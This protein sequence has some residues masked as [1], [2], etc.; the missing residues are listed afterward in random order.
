[1]P[2]GRRHCAKPR[3]FIV[4][5]IIGSEFKRLNETE[6]PFPQADGSSYS[7]TDPTSHAGLV[8]F[9]VSADIE[10][11][12]QLLTW[13]KDR[14]SIMNQVVLSSLPL[15]PMPKTYVLSA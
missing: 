10:N 11:R 7:E 4:P 1:M 15:A 13:V 14:N 5:T 9:L 8:N 2:F 3:R 6:H 12:E